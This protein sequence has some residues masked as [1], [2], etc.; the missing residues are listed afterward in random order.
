MVNCRSKSTNRADFSTAGAGNKNRS[1]RVVEPKQAQLSKFNCTLARESYVWV[2]GCLRVRRR[3]SPR[4]G[5][6]HLKPSRGSPE[7][8][9]NTRPSVHVYNTQMPAAG[10]VCARPRASTMTSSRLSRLRHRARTSLN[11]AHVYVY[12]LTRG[13]KRPIDSQPARA[14]RD[15][16]S[17]SPSR[18]HARLGRLTFLYTY[19]YM[20]R[21]PARGAA[22]VSPA[23]SPTATRN[24]FTVPTTVHVPDV[25]LFT[26]YDRH[27]I[28]WSSHHPA[29]LHLN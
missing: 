21:K 13:E 8:R 20:A 17:L 3:G 28:D 24:S 7:F 15:Q 22:S 27:L 29:Q 26:I 19:T 25:G 23:G 14:L 2:W 1:L 11:N 5:G 4:S 12:I 18:P 16:L 10:R 9:R 6:A